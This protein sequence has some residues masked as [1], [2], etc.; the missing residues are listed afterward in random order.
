MYI[1]PHK[2]WL[3]DFY[4]VHRGCLKS[5]ADSWGCIARI[6]ETLEAQSPELGLLLRVSV[7]G[8]GRVYKLRDTLRLQ[9]G[10]TIGAL[11]LGEH[12]AT[13]HLDRECQQTKP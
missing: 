9:A 8:A 10:T 11:H 1:C 6:N 4:E 3:L 2:E 13:W 7:F 12:S 5:S